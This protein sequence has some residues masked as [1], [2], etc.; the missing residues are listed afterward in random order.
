MAK[1]LT[2][3]VAQAGPDSY[4]EVEQFTGTGRV[5]LRQDDDDQVHIIILSTE[6]E[7]ERVRD[8]LR[9]ASKEL[10]RRR[11][12]AAREAARGTQG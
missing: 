12:A 8:A 6:D 7:I 3:F 2:R 5:Y 10:G 9:E 1:L 4:T 11:R